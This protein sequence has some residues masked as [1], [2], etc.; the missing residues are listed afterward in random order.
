MNIKLKRHFLP[1]L[2][3]ISFSIELHAQQKLSVGLTFSP[4]YSHLHVTSKSNSPTRYSEDNPLYT[5]SAGI[6]LKY[7]FSQFISIQSGLNY[8]EYGT[9]VHYKNDGQPYYKTFKET[10]DLK[11]IHSYKS[12]PLEL[13]FTFLRKNNLKLFASVG[14]AYYF[15]VK[16][17]EVRTID[18]QK[19]KRQE[20]ENHPFHGGYSLFDNAIDIQT[21]IGLVYT[22]GNLELS[23]QPKYRRM[24]TNNVYNSHGLDLKVYY[25]TIGLEFGAFYKL[26]KEQKVKKPMNE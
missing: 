12:I 23:I 13:Q 21:G 10:L 19:G 6:H 3:F 17:Y 22:T 5:Y 4:N 18:G 7:A 16:T 14:S 11:N 26:G 8:S 15:S 25:Y 20:I 9:K 2:M 1:V 24:I